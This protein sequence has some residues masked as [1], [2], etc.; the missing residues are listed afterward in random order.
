[1]QEKTKKMKKIQQQRHEAR[2]RREKGGVRRTRREI[3]RKRGIV[4]RRGKR[5]RKGLKKRGAMR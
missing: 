3:R 1:M 2:F 5:G 4:W